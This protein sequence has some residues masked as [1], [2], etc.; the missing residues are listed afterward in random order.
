[1]DGLIIRRMVSADA[2]ALADLFET[3]HK[4]IE[5][6]EQYYLDMLLDKRLVLVALRPHIGLMGYVTLVWQ[7]DYTV[8]WQRSVPEIKD[9]NVMSQFQKRGIG[10]ALIYTCEQA[11]R[12]RRYVWIGISVVQYDPDYDAANRLY[13]ALGYVPDGFGI[14]RADNELHLVKTL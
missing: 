1:M 11:A 13:P 3:W 12:E 5:Q 4:P 7:S 6:F 2:E 9:L 8:F 10:S 14:T